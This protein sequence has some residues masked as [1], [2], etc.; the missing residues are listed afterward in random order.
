MSAARVTLRSAV[1]TS[2]DLD[3]WT[4]QPSLSFL[5]YEEG[6]GGTIGSA[7][8][9]QDWGLIAEEGAAAATVTELDIV[10]KF[11]RVLRELRTGETGHGDA[12]TVDGV[13]Y[14][15]VWHGKILAPS[16]PMLDGNGSTAFSASE[17]ACVL[18]EA[19]CRVGRWVRD[20]GGATDCHVAF[21]LPVFNATLKG[22]MSAGTYSVGGMTVNIHDLRPGY[23]GAEWTAIKIINNLIACN[24]RHEQPPTPNGA[25]QVGLSCTI[26]D[27]NGC[28]NYVPHVFDARGKTIAQVLNELAAEERGM[29]WR[30]TVTSGA[31]VVTVRSTTAV[32]VSVGEGVNA[33]T[34]PA[35]T[36]SWDIDS[37]DVWWWPV[38]V[39][40]N[41]D[42]QADI[43]E[44]R[45]GVCRTGITLGL[46]GTGDPWAGDATA[47]LT[48]G[49]TDDEETGFESFLSDN[50]GT[51]RTVYFERVWRRFVIR[52]GWDGGQYGGSVGL[53]NTAYFESDT[54]LGYGVD[55]W[56]GELNSWQP[57]ELSWPA[58][59][60]Q[61]AAN[62]P[63]GQGFTA[64]NVGQEQVYVIVAE[65]TESG[66]WVDHSHDWAVTIESNP[67][68]VVVDDGAMGLTISGI[69][70]AGRKILVT[71]GIE[72]AIPLQ[73][74]WCAASTAWANAQPRTK[75]IT[76]PDIGT[77]RVL[78]GAVR[79]VNTDMS[80]ALVTVASEIVSRDGTKKLNAALAQARTWFAEPNT[81]VSATNRGAWDATQTTGPGSIIHQVIDGAK[82][83]T[84]DA[85]VTKRIVRRETKDGVPYWSTSYVTDVIAP[86][87][88]AWQ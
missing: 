49:W 72:E 2:A 48:K 81:I 38:N 78:V 15:A 68:A 64:L 54:G 65:D 28:L 5:S 18:N 19:A 17:I 23:A 76:R 44:I 69:L 82:V 6:E 37:S 60:L 66:K 45:G 40:T 41:A 85:V 58:R 57:G 30:A 29:T 62:I 73:V 16:S 84:C 42:T 74:S 11:V 55:G 88:E 13:N 83:K 10:G 79:G 67:P 59:G 47:Q 70:K 46:W 51:T 61:A 25:G 27:P 20:D 4:T 77:D 33:W 71:L 75:L 86:S 14:N 26:N 50:P 39:T 52:D 31:I 22:D 1:Q 7:T 43:I 12:V 3:T 53:W 56:R 8:F 21:D 34:V 36:E 87:Q 63:C 32:A 35:N 24:L 9:S 80:G